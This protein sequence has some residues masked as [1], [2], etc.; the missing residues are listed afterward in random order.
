[1]EKLVFWIFRFPEVAGG[2]YFQVFKKK[3]SLVQVFKKNG[4]PEVSGGRRRSPETQKTKFFGNS[5]FSFYF[6]EF[7][8]PGALRRS[9]EVA[10]GGFFQNFKKNGWPEVAGG[11]R[12]RKKNKFFGKFTFL[13]SRF[14][15]VAG[16]RRRS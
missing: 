9:P 7:S 2:V 14:P 16:G 6:L 11:R 5:R 12:R 1:M 10:G 15:E 8:V 4:S 13:N 3:W